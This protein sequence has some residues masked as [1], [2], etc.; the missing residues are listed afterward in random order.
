MHHSLSWKGTASP[1]RSTLV[2]KI[3]GK[4]YIIKIN[5]SLQKFLNIQQHLFANKGF[6]VLSLLLNIW[7]AT[8]KYLFLYNVLC[9]GWQVKNEIETNLFLNLK[10]KSYSDEL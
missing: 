5:S 1:N 7:A 6:L 4:Q 8:F 9:V 10:S 3:A 2:P